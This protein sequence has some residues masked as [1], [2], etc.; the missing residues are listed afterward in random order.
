M[1]IQEI[2]EQKCNDN[3]DICQHLPTL[4]EYA[5][6]CDLVVELG[7]RS[8]VSTWA[9]LMGKPDWLISVDIEH[10]SY[11][12]DYDKDGCNIEL[13]YEKAKEQETLFE[14]IEHDSLTVILPVCDLMF[15]DT[16]HTYWQLSMELKAH[17]NNVNKYMIFHDTETYKKELMPAITEYLAENSHWQID[18][19]FYNN[20]GLLILKNINNVHD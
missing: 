4:K 1:T 13:V 19:I 16:L 9:F 10:P 20:N 8:I 11:Y 17:G 3:S 6:K 18:K 14:F 15:F 2:Y 12:Q 7:V 5:E